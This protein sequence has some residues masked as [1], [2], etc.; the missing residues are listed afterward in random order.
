MADSFDFN[1]AWEPQDGITAYVSDIGAGLDY[2]TL[3]D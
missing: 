2:D 3:E 1:G